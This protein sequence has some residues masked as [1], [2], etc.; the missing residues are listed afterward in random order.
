LIEDADFNRMA[1]EKILIV[2]DDLIIRK[3][4]ED[5]LRKKR[6]SVVSAPNLAEAERYLA[7]DHFDLVLADIR[8][9]DGDGSSLL[10]RIGRSS[11]PPLTV[12][13][14]AHG[15]IESA[16]NCM[17]SGAFDYVIKPFSPAEIEMTVKKADAFD[18]VMRVNHHLSHESGGSSELIGESPAM[19][20][21]KQLIRKVARTD[22][23]VLIHGESGTGKEM[24][25][26]EL[27]RSSSR[28]NAPFI[29]VNCAAI[30]E[31][32]ME[33]EFF[34]HEKGSFTGAMDR[35]EGRFEL[36]DK[37][38]I[39]LD[40]ISEIS[41]NL[42]AKL[43]RVLQERE[44]ERVGGN[45]T[46]KVDVRVVATTNRNLIRA[47][48]K[49]EFRE[50]LYYR[51]N[52]FPLAVPALRERPDDILLLAQE[53]LN[54]SARRHGL[55]LSGFSDAARA[56]LL[57]HGWPGNVRELQ[58]CV[59]R[60]VILVDEGARI[61]PENLGIFPAAPKGSAHSGPK[62]PP[63]DL[64]GAAP[65]HGEPT[66]DTTSQRIGSAMPL[67]EIEREHILEVLR[68]TAGNRT[69]AASILKISIR[70]LRNKLNEYKS[71]GIPIIGSAGEDESAA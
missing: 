4:L 63:A 46:L 68:G 50:D 67:E 41:P 7:K 24:V 55:R 66:S 30:T 26:S 54:R 51:L 15:T 6:Y 69:Q 57:A 61:E 64:P 35:R 59:E 33:S 1:I 70:T 58:N 47:V 44:F 53:F 52:V 45:K 49:K 32:L 36:A 39:L 29:K 60:A 31:N 14:T 65:A 2:D 3:S 48:E 17:R 43:L 62:I 34:G 20:Q 25:A 23:T 21:L 56:A 16:V 19:Q 22:A 27:F 38:T 8:L 28:S 42:Q 13:I 71:A 10:E 18:H 37:G 11:K 40:E 12:M 9:P 5:M